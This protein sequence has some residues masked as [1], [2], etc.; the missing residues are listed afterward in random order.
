MVEAARR[1]AVAVGL[2]VAVAKAAVRAAAVRAAAVAEA[3]TAVAAAVTAVTVADAVQSRVVVEEAVAVGDQVGVRAV[4]PRG[5]QAVAAAAAMV[6]AAVGVEV[7]NPERTAAGRVE[8]VVAS[9]HTLLVARAF[10]T[11]RAGQGGTECRPAAIGS[12][13][14]AGCGRQCA[15]RGR[16][17]VPTC[18][19]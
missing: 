15:C 12:H 1:V 10:C 9:S 4:E 11:R 3:A 19:A 5:A 18:T 8:K 6:V 13:F 16:A 7:A 14:A 17:A 2:V